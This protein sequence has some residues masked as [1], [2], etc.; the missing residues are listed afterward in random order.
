MDRSTKTPKMNCK[1]WECGVL[2]PVVAK[3]GGR[4][5]GGTS[6]L[7]SKRKVAL[8]M[9]VFGKAIPVPMK[10]PAEPLEGQRPWFFRDLR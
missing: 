5:L 1:N 2:F 10:V 6:P 4:T 8:G 7:E 3:D 9:E